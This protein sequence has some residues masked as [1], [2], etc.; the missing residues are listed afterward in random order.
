MIYTNIKKNWL[1]LLKIIYN[2][3]DGVLFMYCENCGK[4]VSGKF[5]SECGCALKTKIEDQS[6]LIGG[7]IDTEKKNIFGIASSDVKDMAML[8]KDKL[9][10]KISEKR[11]QKK[12]QKLIEKQL[13]KEN[14]IAEKQYEKERIKDLKQNKVAYCPKCK[15]TSLTADKKGYGIGKGVVGAAV[16][17]NPL[18]LVAGNLGSKKVKVTCLN[19]GYKFTPGQ[20]MYL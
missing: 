1:R 3:E 19:C 7:N 8:A 10:N 20:K 5:C 18:G 15:S 13:K 4:E 17:G 6:D 16:V 9:A 2:K 11:E 12:E 14:K